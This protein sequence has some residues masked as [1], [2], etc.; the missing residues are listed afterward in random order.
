MSRILLIAYFL[1][2]GL[3][4]LVAPWSIVWDRNLFVETLPF[5]AS[6]ARLDGVRGAVSGVGLVSLGI[7]VRE[8]MVVLGG[9]LLRRRG[10]ERLSPPAA[11][12]RTLAEEAGSWLRKR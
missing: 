5:W 11:V 6:V 9:A 2:T 3:V 8:L 7:G 10:S 12:E 4:L 1:E